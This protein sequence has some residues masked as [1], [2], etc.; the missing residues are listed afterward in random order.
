[1]VLDPTGGA[2]VLL[3]GADNK[4]H[5]QVITLGQM[6]G[7][8][9]QVLNGLKAGDRVIAEGAMKLKDKGDIK[10]QPIKPAPNASEQ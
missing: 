4:A 3:A 1:V 9:W 10:A 8:Q 6:Q 2:S 5:K 7:N